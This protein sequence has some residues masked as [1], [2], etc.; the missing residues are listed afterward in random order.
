LSSFVTL[1]RFDASSILKS[2]L[3]L[4][5][6]SDDDTIK[7]T[8]I[9]THLVNLNYQRYSEVVNFL[10]VKTQNALQVAR[11]AESKLDYINE[12]WRQRLGNEEGV[13]WSKNFQ[14]DSLSELVYW[15]GMKMKRSR[16][17][18]QLALQNILRLSVD[19]FVGFAGIESTSWNDVSNPP[20]IILIY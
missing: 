8:P 2:E 16:T 1:Q 6:A 10:L 11:M 17:E 3:A 18:K 19:S 15:V 9:L 7:S 4:T 12:T 13:L 14:F 20:K 5:R